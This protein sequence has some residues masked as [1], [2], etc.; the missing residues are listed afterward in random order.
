M[1]KLTRF[2]AVV[3]SIFCTSAV[4]SVN[5]VNIN[6]VDHAIDTIIPKHTIGPGTSYAFYHLPNRPLTIH[7]LEVDLNNQYV[8]LEACN[9]G[10]KSVATELT[11]NMYKRNDSPGHD[12]IAAHNGSFFHTSETDQTAVGMSRM[13]LIC[14]G[15]ILQNPVGWPLFILTQDRVSY[16]ENVYF[17]ASIST[18]TGS[19]RIHTLNTHLLELESLDD[20]GERMM[21]F[22]REYGT[23]TN[24]ATGGTKVVLVPKEGDFTIT[25]NMT[26]NCTVESIFDNTGASDIPEGK[27]VLYG[28]GVNET[29]LKG[30]TVGEECTINIATT[31]PTV[32]SIDN[33]KEGLGGSSHFILRDGEVVISGNPDIH[34]RTFM[35]ISKDGKT[36][37]SVAVDGRWEGSAGVTLDDEGR[38]LKMLGAWHGLNLDG[39]GSTTMVVH[40]NITNHV[41]GGSE[42]AVGDA[43]LVYSSAPVDDNIAKI[44]FE[45]RAYNVPITARF[46]PAIYAYNQYDLIK[47]KDLEGVKLSCDPE[48]GSFNENNEFIATGEVAS[49]YIYAEYNG[50]TTKQLVN[51]IMSPL[52]LVYDSYV[53]DDKDDYP[54]LMNG[55]VGNFVYDADAASVTWAIDDETICSVSDGKV[56][57]IKNGVATLTGT[58]DNFNGNVTINVE[59]PEKETKSMFPAFDASAWT[60]SQSGGENQTIVED[61]EGIKIS[62]TGKS[63]RS[64]SL[65]LYSNTL[66][67]YGLPKAI[68]MDI[69]PGDAIVKK[70]QLSFRTNNKNSGTVYLTTSQLAKNENNTFTIDIPNNWA[71]DYTNYPIILNGIIFSMGSSTTNAQY[72]I[73]IS[74]LE[75]IYGDPSGIEDVISNN[76]I[77][78]YPNP[79]VSGTPVSIEADGVVNVDIYTLGGSLVNSI[80]LT[81]N[82]TIETSGMTAGMYILHVTGETDVYTTKMIIK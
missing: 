34:P 70:I 7:V 16:F 25:P 55:T 24:S 14:N 56:R 68:K 51:T 76:S 22:T 46:R 39:G 1:R 11:T 81:D 52:S 12:M 74:K 35:G 30:L 58:S 65:S 4:F 59:I 80:K 53:V 2:L 9:G 57:G 71:D 26:I 32:P 50:I 29:F 69:N 73:T 38:I 10:Q 44:A 60:I 63:S 33:I 27:A 75:Q 78:V 54:I 48:I 40:G 66:K 19:N 67:T 8:Q 64:P 77:G 41:S 37:Y 28:T 45:P 62:Y 3:A 47:N 82:K 21:M 23:K 20:A 42:R 72:D 18:A 13:G 5:T 15:E 36:V 61:G 49:G 43:L 31:V 79:V 17:N 6:G